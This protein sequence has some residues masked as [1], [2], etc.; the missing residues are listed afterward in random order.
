M[1]FDERATY[2][3]L[4]QRFDAGAQ[5][6]STNLTETFDYERF[7]ERYPDAVLLFVIEGDGRLSV[8]TE[9]DPPEPGP[10][11]KVIAIVGQVDQ[12]LGE[13]SPTPRAAEH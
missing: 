8:F 3:N 4:T 9:D 5:L 1:L 6:K 12:D 2:E 11:D 13:A 7:K 10:G